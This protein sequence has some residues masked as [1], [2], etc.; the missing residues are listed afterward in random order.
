MPEGV[1]ENAIGLRE[2]E[3]SPV[4]RNIHAPG[5][6]SP[7]SVPYTYFLPNFDQSS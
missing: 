4:F 3:N 2:N 5:C 6:F 7:A 1:L